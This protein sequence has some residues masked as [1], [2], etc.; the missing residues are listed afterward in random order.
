MY[1]VEPRYYAYYISLLLKTFFIVSSRMIIKKKK[2]F[3]RRKIFKERIKKIKDQFIIPYKHIILL[4]ILFSN[5]YN[6]QGSNL[7]KCSIMNNTTTF[8]EL[9]T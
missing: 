8:Q 7:L 6:Y 4:C 1:L 2:Y 3:S 9:V 5:L